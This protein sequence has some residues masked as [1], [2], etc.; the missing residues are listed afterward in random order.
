M[1][2]EVV[3]GNLGTVYQG[4]DVVEAINCYIAY[5]RLSRAGTG[6]AGNEPVTLLRNG[7][8]KKEHRSTI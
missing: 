6:R 8:I 2:Y 4:E 5:V 3:V 1:I 7:E